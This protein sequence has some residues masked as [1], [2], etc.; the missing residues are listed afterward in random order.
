MKFLA[1][2]LT[3]HLFF[4]TTNAQVKTGIEVLKNQNFLLLKGKKVGL[5]TN[6]T[7]VD[8]GLKS[9]IDVL[10]EAPEV[11]LVALFGPEH[12]VRGNVA[13][14]EKV[15]NLTDP[16]T[17]LPVFSLYGKTRKPTPQMLSGIDALV[18]DIQDIGSRSYTYISTLG[19]A[20]EA[21]A[22]NNIE[23]IVLDRPNPLGG[24]KFE[25]PLTEEAFTSFVS[26]F[27]IPYVHGFTVGELATFINNNHLLPNNL[28]CQLTVVKMEGWHRDML[29]EETG[30]QWVP[31]SPH[32]PH[33]HSAYFYPVSGIL[34][35]LYVFNIGVGYTLPFQTFATDWI[36][37]GQLARNLNE[38]K[39]PGII[40]RPIHYKPY[41]STYKGKEIQGVQ[42]HLTNVQK[43][44]LSLIQFY[45]L[46]EVHKL[47]PDKNVFEM[48]DPS[49]LNMFDKVCG[50]DKVRK[51][52]SKNFRVEDI[53]D[54]W[55]GDINNFL[56]K[57]G[58]SFLY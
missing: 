58:K 33:A 40:F 36:D 2:L 16:A 53:I 7:G 26:Q 44:P 12:G 21:A 19:L 37:A 8:A 39:L 22:E 17:G 51:A 56:K 43:A 35:E 46:Q 45:V 30:L 31:S 28:K 15:E 48:C 24:N 23:F 47:H 32:I 42:V 27:P 6:P 14:G 38:L 50:T 54:I 57:A 34:G 10:N 1:F 29:F 25:G 20:M 52:F 5:I 13:A 49:R 9:T 4:A 3:I 41:Y 11:D 18:Y 55:Y